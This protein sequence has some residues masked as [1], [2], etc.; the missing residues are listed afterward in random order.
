MIT[1]VEFYLRQTSNSDAN[2]ANFT[3]AW[4]VNAIDWVFRAPYVTAYDTHPPLPPD[5]GHG[6]P[7]VPGT[8]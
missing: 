4:P 7:S 2:P 8:P 3:K 1:S 5:G 6:S